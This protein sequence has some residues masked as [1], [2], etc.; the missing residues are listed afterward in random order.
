MLVLQIA[1]HA[2][3]QITQLGCAQHVQQE[4]HQC[5]EA[6]VA[7]SFIG[8]QRLAKAA[9]LIAIDD[10]AHLKR[11]GV[12]GGNFLLCA[13]YEPHAENLHAIRALL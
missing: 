10:A 11:E 2:E 5:L 13:G 1:S 6:T 4:H 3:Q 8:Q 9:K 12:K 7:A